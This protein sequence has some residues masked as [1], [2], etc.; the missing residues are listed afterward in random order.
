MAKQKLKLG[1]TLAEILRDS[2]NNFTEV[3]NML[4]KIQEAM[5]DESDKAYTYLTIADMINNLPQ[6]KDGQGNS[7]PTSLNIGDEILILDDLAPDFWVSGNASDYSSTDYETATANTVFKKGVNY[8]VGNYILRVSNDRE[9]Q[10]EDY[11]RKD[12][13]DTTT[14]G[15]STD[16]THYPSSPLVNSNLILK[17]NL[18]N[19]V[20]TTQD[21]IDAGVITDKLQVLNKALAQTAYPSMYALYEWFFSYGA[22]LTDVSKRRVVQ[23]SLDESGDFADGGANGIT[24]EW[25]THAVDYGGDIGE[26]TYKA[27]A[28]FRFEREYSPQLLNVFDGHNRPIT[29]EIDTDTVWGEVDGRP[30]NTHDDIYICLDEKKMVRL[31]C[32]V[33]EFYVEKPE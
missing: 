2:N 9:I 33:N 17:E 30:T 5:T 14:D 15:F 31:I 27:T 23:I 21:L 25:V 3:Y 11:Q 29:Y 28:R 26:K 10:L 12:N 20:A 24:G 22:E 19:K 1:A 13:L 16:D 7:L 8:K 32:W 18:V 6:G 4:A